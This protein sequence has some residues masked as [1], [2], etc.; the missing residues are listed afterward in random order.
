MAT[1]WVPPPYTLH[2]P[3]RHSSLHTLASES[4]PST[5][6]AHL[7]EV[8]PAIPHLQALAV[9]ATGGWRLALDELEDTGFQMRTFAG[10]PAIARK[11]G[12]TRP[13]AA[14]AAVK[15]GP[16]AL[17]PLTVPDDVGFLSAL[18]QERNLPA[19]LAAGIAQLY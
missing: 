19:G 16:I 6:L 14:R 10:L 4:W 9:A 7:G 18:A 11:A 12:V 8:S 15:L 2:P 1:L 13:L 5:A 3:A 17:D